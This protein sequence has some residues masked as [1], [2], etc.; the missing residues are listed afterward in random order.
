LTDIRHG[1]LH[2]LLFEVARWVLVND[3]AGEIFSAGRARAI[4]AARTASAA[5]AAACRNKKRISTSLII[6]ETNIL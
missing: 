2:A 4:T 3:A 1:R 5:T 6:H